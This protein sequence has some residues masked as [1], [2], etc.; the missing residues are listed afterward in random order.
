M[1][2]AGVVVDPTRLS[3]GPGC[4]QAREQMLV[5]ALFA[6]APV[7]ALVEA[8]LLRLTRRSVVPL[9]R[10]PSCQRRIAYEG[11]SGPLSETGL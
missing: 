9:D 10:P 8:V 11:N 3:D 2:A 1:R 5:Q 6:Q 4:R 7:Q